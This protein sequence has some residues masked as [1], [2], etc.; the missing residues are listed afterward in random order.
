MKQL[1]VKP[2]VN[3]FL[4]PD[5][6]FK[7]YAISL[8]FHT[9]LARETVTETALLPGVLKRGSADFPTTAAI[10]EKLSLLLGARLSTG[11]VKYGE[12]QMLT[13]S[14]KG[15]SDEFSPYSGG[16]SEALRLLFGVALKPLV[17]FR[18]DYLRGEK[19]HLAET[20]ESEKNNK[21]LYAAMRCRAEMCPDEAYALP[22]NGFADEIGAITEER[23]FSRYCEIRDHAPLDILLCGSFSADDAVALITELTEALPDRGETRP[24]TAPAGTGKLP[25]VTEAMDVSQGKLCIGFTCPVYEPQDADYPAMM[26]ANSIFGGGVHSKLFLNV[27]EKLSLAYYAGSSYERA[28]GIVLVSSGIESANFEKAKDEIFLQFRAM[29]SGDFS[30]TDLELSKKHL[31]HTYRTVTDAPGDMISFSLG[32]ILSGGF[33]T[34]DEMIGKIENTSLADVRRVAGAM[35]ERLIYFLK[36][37]DR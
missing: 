15:V 12:D 27:R 4:I 28:K 7:T 23:L 21:R 35:K 11:V 33:F 14:L 2:G 8:F 31:C 1:T 10:N 22:E 37:A 29:T 17:P 24:R 18:E 30:Q 19:Q 36:G 34:P 20:I 9:P 16:F 26:L 5:N 3:L 13:F 6:K 25:D 32:Q